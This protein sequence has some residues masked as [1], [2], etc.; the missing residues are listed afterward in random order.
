MD[1]TADDLAN[2]PIIAERTHLAIDD[3][4]RFRHDRIAKLNCL[5]AVPRPPSPVPRFRQVDAG[6]NH[7]AAIGERP[8]AADHD[9]GEHRYL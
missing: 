5:Q 1:H 2:A 8:G 7:P 3:G 4:K 9:R 6:S